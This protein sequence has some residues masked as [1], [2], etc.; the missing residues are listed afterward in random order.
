M[1]ENEM[2]D[3]ELTDLETSGDAGG[4]SGLNPYKSAIDAVFSGDETGNASPAPDG[5]DAF[6]SYKSAIDAV[7][8]G[9]ENGA[10]R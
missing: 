4:D 1:S 2:H 5:A 6:A 7:L 10:G 8:G 9:D 3:D